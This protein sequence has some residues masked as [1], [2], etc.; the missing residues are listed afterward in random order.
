MQAMRQEFFQRSPLSHLPKWGG[1]QILRQLPIIPPV[2]ASKVFQQL[3][4]I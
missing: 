4:Q 3:L 1:K 2:V